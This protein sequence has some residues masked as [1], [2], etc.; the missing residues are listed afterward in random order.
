MV[1]NWVEFGGLFPPA[2]GL[3]LLFRRV[4]EG[5][6]RPVGQL[7]AGLLGCAIPGGAFGVAASDGVLRGEGVRP[8]RWAPSPLP[9][10]TTR[11]SVNVSHL[12][13]VYS[14]Y[15]DIAIRFLL[16]SHYESRIIRVQQ[17]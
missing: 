7:L 4:V 8:L 11:H 2:A 17:D 1:T 13:E 15:F 16:I 5:L 9:L 14:N 12:Q 10:S 3:A 6:T